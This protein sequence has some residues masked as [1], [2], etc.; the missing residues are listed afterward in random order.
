M[1]QSLEYLSNYIRTDRLRELF[2][3]SITYKK[4]NLDVE[5]N[6]II[7]QDNYTI[8]NISLVTSNIKESIELKNYKMND[9]IVFLLNLVDKYKTEILLNK[10]DNLL[11]TKR[12]FT[13]VKLENTN[14]INTG[15]DIEYFYNFLD[16]E[17]KEI[18]RTR[19]DTMG[20]VLGGLMGLY[21]AYKI[22]H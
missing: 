4:I 21:F 22:T 1:F 16:Y 17:V 3:K 7:F 5:H 20:I 14:K 6:E 9:D 11:I 15:Y 2:E 10:A 12:V 19:R 18:Q 8:D 13:L